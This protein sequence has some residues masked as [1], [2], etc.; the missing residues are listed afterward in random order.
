V[1]ISETPIVEAGEIDD[2]S[3]TVSFRMS[4]A[5]DKLKTG[6]YTVQAV[7]LQPGGE[8]SA[9]GRG[10][11]ALRAPSAPAAAAAPTSPPSR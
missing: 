4:M 3:R 9:F 11:F 10:Y 1:K 2:A 8:L 5:L 6:R 7:T